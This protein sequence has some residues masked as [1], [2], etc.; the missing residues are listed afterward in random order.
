MALI[1]AH[2]VKPCY[3]RY[4]AYLQVRPFTNSVLAFPVKFPPSSS[5]LNIAG[6]LQK[7]SLYAYMF[8]VDK[9]AM[10][11]VTIMMNSDFEDVIHFYHTL[12]GV[13]R[14]KWLWE[15]VYKTNLIELPQGCTKT[16]IFKGY[17]NSKGPGKRLFIN[18]QHVEHPLDTSELSSMSHS[19]HLSR[20][21]GVRDA[22]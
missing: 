11:K 10:M 1:I 19:D 6:H 22:G 17:N 20:G 2:I 13:L 12:K 15:T 18:I 21:W 9:T 7:L 3:R 8:D 14:M 16:T 4:V 5:Q